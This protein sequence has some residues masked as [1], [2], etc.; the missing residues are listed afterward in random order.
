MWFII[1]WF[2]S[3]AYHK[4]Q[5]KPLLCL[6]YQD[7]QLDPTGKDFRTIFRQCCIPVLRMFRS[8]VRNRIRPHR[9]HPTYIVLSHH[10]SLI[11]MDVELNGN[12]KEPFVRIKK[13]NVSHMLFYVFVQPHTGN[14][15][16]N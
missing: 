1:I 3:D 4:D 6:D 8:P 2:V 5:C 13:E 14:V 12:V 10:T 7:K 11:H 16:P 9:A 15:Y